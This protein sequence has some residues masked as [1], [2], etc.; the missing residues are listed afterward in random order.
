MIISYL[1]VT[2]RKD[3]QQY[4]AQNEPYHFVSVAEF[5]K[6]FQSFHVGRQLLRELQTPFNKEKSH[7]SALSTSV[8]GAPKME[9]LKACMSRELLL[10][11]RNSFVYIFKLLQVRETPLSLFHSL[12][13][14]VINGQRR[15]QL[16]FVAFVT[17][18]LFLRTEMRRESAEDGGIFLGALYIGLMTHLFNGYAELA[19]SIIRLPVFYKQRDLG[20]Y[21]SWAYAI[22]SWVLKI[23]ISLVECAL[24]TALTYYAVGFDPNIHR[25]ISDTPFSSLFVSL[26]LTFFFNWGSISAR[27]FVLWLSL[28]EE[29]KIST[30]IH[31]SIFCCQLKQSIA[32]IL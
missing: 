3:Q 1:Q 11:K 20:F 22:P 15:W 17:M 24:W 6:A 27:A 9:L 14:P 19:M 28:Y 8:Y 31:P 16:V 29:T 32:L 18:T 7:P 26:T 23:P 13:S 10:M 21:P 30:I 12:P 4:W 25:Y 2:S 5:A